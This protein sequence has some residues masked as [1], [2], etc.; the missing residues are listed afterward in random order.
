MPIT[1]ASRA[2]AKCLQK[3]PEKLQNLADGTLP[4]TGDPEQPSFDRRFDPRRRVRPVEAVL[5]SRKRPDIHMAGD[6]T[7]P[8]VA[9]ISDCKPFGWPLRVSQ[10]DEDRDIRLLAYEGTAE[11]WAPAVPKRCTAVRERAMSRASP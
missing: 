10:F 1:R 8:L 9:R 4:T 7:E 5:A 11:R 2:A 3:V 6:A